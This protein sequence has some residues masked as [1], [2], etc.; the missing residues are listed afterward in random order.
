MDYKKTYAE[1]NMVLPFNAYITVQQQQRE[2]MVVMEFLAALPTAY[3]FAR[4]HIL[5]SPTI[6]SLEDAYNRMAF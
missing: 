5:A 6:T 3:D 1:L 2:Q 4:A